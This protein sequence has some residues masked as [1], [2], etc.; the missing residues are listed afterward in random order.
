VELSVA[1]KLIE[2]GIDNREK[3]QVWADLGCGTGLFS[4][5]LSSLLPSNSTIHSVDKDVRAL[6][7][8]KKTF[9]DDRRIQTHVLDF[10][11]DE[12]PFKGLDGI[13]IANA[14]HFVDD[15]V[16]ALKRFKKILKP[17]GKIILIEYDLERSN[18]WVPFPITFVRLRQ[19]I[20]QSGFNEVTKIAE[21]PSR[22]HEAN[23]YSSVLN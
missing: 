20:K 11:S 18:P 14:L 16:N 21:A 15:Q 17:S 2:R 6:T 23:I 12:L 10:T 8:L 4:Q 22:Y 13:V 5:A 9:G 3:D 19:I 1:V 7:T